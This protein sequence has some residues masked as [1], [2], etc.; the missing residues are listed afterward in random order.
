MKRCFATVLG[1]FLST[2]AFSQKIPL[3]NSGEVLDSASRHHDSGNYQKSIEWLQKIPARDTNYMLMQVRLAMSYLGNKE[4]DKAIATCD[5]VLEKPSLESK[6]ALRTKGLAIGRSGAYE[7]AVAFFEAELKKSPID[8]GLM[9]NLALIHYENKSYEKA[10]NGYFKVL[11]LYPYHSS[12][13]YQLGRIAREMGHST[14]AMMAMGIY[15]S[16]NPSDNSTLVNFNGYLDNP[17][18][19]SPIPAVGSNGAEKLDKIVRAKIAMEKDYKSEVPIKASVVRQFELFFDQL[20]T[21]TKDQD[22]LWGRF[23]LPIYLKLKENQLKLPFVYHILSSAKNDDMKKW[24]NKN[25][26]ATNAFFD[27]MN[28]ALR[29]KRA[30]QTIPELGVTTPTMA[31]FGDNNAIEAIGKYVDEKYLG[32]WIFFNEYYNTSAVGVF[33]DKGVKTG[34]WTYYHPEGSVKRI[35]NHETGEVNLFRT[36]GSKQETFFLKNEKTTGVVMIYFKGGPLKEKVNYVDD[37]RHGGGETYFTTGKIHETFTYEKGKLKGPAKVYYENGQLSEDLN[38]V[39]GKLDGK[40]ASFHVNGKRGATGSYKA[41]NS[42]GVW[43]IYYR[44]G[45]IQRTGSYTDAG[46]PTGEWTYYDHDGTLTEKRNFDSEGRYHG[47]SN[48]YYNGKLHYTFAYKKDLIVGMEFFN[49]TGK[50]IAKFGNNDGTFSMKYYFQSG[51]VEM[52]GAYRKGKIDGTWKGYDRFGK[53]LSVAEYKDGLITSRVT[54][55]PTGEKKETISYR[56][57][58]YDGYYTEYYRNGKVSTEGWYKD[59]EQQQ[60]WLSYHENGA[61]SYDGYYIDG[62]SHGLHINYNEDGSQSSS[63]EFD[64]NY[65][66]DTDY[67][68]KGL[69]KSKRKEGD[70]WIYETS[71]SNKKTATHQEILNG[72]VSKSLARY[73]PDGSLFFKY[74]YMTGKRHGVYSYFD[75]L[76]IKQVSGSF[77]EG[78]RQDQ[79]TYYHS[80]G[81]VSSTGRCWDGD[82]DS[83]WTY[84]YPDGRVKL[85]SNFKGDERHGLTTYYSVEGA[86]VIELVYDN[87]QI[88]S[89][90]DVASNPKSEFLPFSGNGKIQAKYPNG[91]IAW[92][93]EFKNGVR[94]GMYRLTQSNGKVLAEYPHVDGENH[95]AYAEYYPNGKVFEKGTYK[96]GEQDGKL[97]EYNEN[98]TLIRSENYVSGMLHGKCIYYKNG[99]KHKEISY[100]YGF[101]EN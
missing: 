74:E 24:K 73:Y 23:Y 66:V 4:Y 5:K 68:G 12:A 46:Q 22:D 2:C 51:E 27:A 59:G 10:V 6:Q 72:V 56:D 54:Y 69:V 29:E 8:P 15:F 67:Y 26:K 20:Q 11:R 83:V 78:N 98:G 35:E 28:G 3:I 97:E 1:L 65:I 47:T 33:N 32:K 45:Q 87:G 76:G 41:G 88:V 52:E 50:S 53:L 93:D 38:Y 31:W 16:V 43:T 39:D 92:E 57:G 99:V 77:E 60:Q 62:A 13:H 94:H 19:E 79:W 90:R 96:N 36:D 82:Q 48:Y 85:V 21:I 7:K 30:E 95:G 34:T 75:P 63:T 49:A 55:F 89:Y 61:V 80:N 86:P 64:H 37:E 44:N 9:F 25:E 84:H 58:K 18:T 17:V 42:V 14:H 40:Y 91:V 71:Y 81:K 100:R 70:S 101:P